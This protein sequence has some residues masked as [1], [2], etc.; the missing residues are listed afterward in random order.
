MSGIPL[1]MLV[2]VALL[3][4]FQSKIGVREDIL[5]RWLNMYDAFVTLDTS[6]LEAPLILVRAVA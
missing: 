2:I 4:I 6:Q 3:A 5:S 1:N